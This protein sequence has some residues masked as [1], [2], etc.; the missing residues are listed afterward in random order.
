M[1][2]AAVCATLTYTFYKVIADGGSAGL[3]ASC[4]A[5][6]H[7]ALGGDVGKVMAEATEQTTMALV[8]EVIKADA[9]FSAI[10]L[11]NGCQVM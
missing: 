6:E 1:G 5:L 8:S 2:V 3:A 11:H 10:V 9:L 4:C 7:L